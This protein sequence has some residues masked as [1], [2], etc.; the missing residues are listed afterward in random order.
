M[1]AFP[2]IFAIGQDYIADIFKDEVEVTEKVDGSQFVFGKLNGEILCR[3]KGAMLY[4]GAVHKMFQTAWDYIHSVDLPEDTIFYGEYLQRPKHNTLCYERVPKNNITIFGVSTPGGTFV[5]NYCALA[6]WADGIGLEAVPLIYR[7]HIN[8]AEELKVML[9][10]NSYLGGVKVEGVV[11]KNY[12]RPFLLGGQPIPLM[13]GKFV[14]EAFKETHIKGWGKENTS[15]GKWDTFKDG[16]RTDARFEKAVQ[17]L[18]DNGELENSPRDIG[19]LISEVKRDI[20]DEEK[21]RILKFLWSE[22]SPELMRRA[23]H[24]LPEWYKE[25]L[26]E[27]AFGN[28]DD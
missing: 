15:K 8:S 13:C 2:K 11:V 25:K 14:S 26:A 16:F 9:D 10:T 20:T 27:Q 21:D 22:F 5:D 4:D 7:G 24:G 6:S 23:T 17:H 18:R 19:K 28:Q 12:V 1:H 3:S